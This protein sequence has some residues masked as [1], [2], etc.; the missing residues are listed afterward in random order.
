MEYAQQTLEIAK[1]SS[2]LEGHIVGFGSYEN[3][4][5]KTDTECGFTA[6]CTESDTECGFT[7]SCN[8]TDTE[9]GFTDDCTETDTECGF[10][11]SD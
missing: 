9:C 5:T 2:K 11:V 4:C 7:D 6:D 3:A 10:A 1:F 8:E